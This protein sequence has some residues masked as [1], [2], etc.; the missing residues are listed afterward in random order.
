MYKTEYCEVTYLEDEN[1]IFCAWKQPCKGDDYR[2][3]FKYAL[4]EITKHNISTWITDTS[5][6]FENEEADT[7]WLIKE[8]MPQLVESSV[9]KIVFVIKKDSPLMNEIMGQVE[10]LSA[11]FEVE[12]VETKEMFL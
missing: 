2:N 1:A 11:Y 8:F 9:N 6:G 3:P 10:A 4:E 12:L 5:K 7:Q